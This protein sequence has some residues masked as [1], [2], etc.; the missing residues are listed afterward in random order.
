MNEPDPETRPTGLDGVDVEALRSVDDLPAGVS[1]LDHLRVVRIQGEDAESFLHGQFSSDVKG[2]PPGE[3]Q[4]GAYCNPKGR[5]IAVYRLL[6]DEEGFNLLLP[7]DLVDIVVRRLT[8]FRM[9]SKVDIDIAGDSVVVGTIG[10]Q[11]PAIN[12]CWTLDPSRAL[13][14]MSESAFEGI[15]ADSMAL[16]A[17]AWKLGEILALEPQVYAATSEEFI[18]QQI[19]LDLV[20]GVSFTKGCYPGQEIIARVRYLGK[21][22]QRMLAA[23]TRPGELTVE[24]GTPLFSADRPDQKSGMVVDAVRIGDSCLV[25]AMLPSSM[26]SG[27]SLLLG[28]ATGPGLDFLPAPYEITTGR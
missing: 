15:L 21:I 17:A 6:R 3:Q 14:L 8:L 10:N 1:R 25:S 4:P 20:G 16:D 27:G 22:K 18:P 9:R 11:L 24:P 7:A 12:D 26:L 28:S 19:N 23:M 2:L 5:A 13:T